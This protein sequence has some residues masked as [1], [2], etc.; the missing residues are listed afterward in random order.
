MPVTV[1]L[2]AA[3]VRHPVGSGRRAWCGAALS[4]QSDLQ[5]WAPSG[6]VPA[7]RSHW[8]IPVAHSCSKVTSPGRRDGEKALSLP[9]LHRGRDR[10]PHRR[11]YARALHAGCKRVVTKPFSRLSQQRPRRGG[12]WPQYLKA[13]P[14]IRGEATAGKA[15]T[16]ALELDVDAKSARE[17]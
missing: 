9:A 16:G 13:S 12:L 2:Q 5:Q 8:L 1:A 15:L 3:G 7:W 17:A 14:A 10:Q 11:S 4:P 6:P